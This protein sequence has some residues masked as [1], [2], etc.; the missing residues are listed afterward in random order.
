VTALLTT[1]GTRIRD[2]AYEVEARRLVRLGLLVIFA[3]LAGAGVWM[4]VTP[5]SGAAIAQGAVKVDMNRK[6]LQHQEGGI[7]KEI[8]VRNG[9]RVE[10]GQTLLVI[11]DV[12]VEANYDLLMTQ[13]DSEM[14]KGARLASESTI[15]GAVDY[16]QELLDRSED[17]RVKEL[18]RRENAV[19]A[20]RRQM[21]DGQIRLL[22]E[23]I[24]EAQREAAA[25]R[26]QV[27][28]ERRAV[29]WQK[30]E[31]QA[32]RKLADQGFMSNTK[33]LALQRGVAEYE[34]RLGEHQAALAQARQR[35]GDF[36]LRIASLRNNY[37]K[38]AADE[39]KD[40]TARIYDLRERLRPSLDAAQRQKVVAPVAGD[41][42]DLRV[43]TVG[44]VVGPREPLLDI[45][46][47]NPELIVES[48]VRPED[49][50]Y[51][52]VGGEADVRLSAFK[53][54]I[55]PTVT[56]KVVYVSADS[57]T[58]PK[59]GATYYLANI[60]LTPESLR[61]AG[62]LQLQAGMPA[63]VFVKTPARTPLQYLLD[64]LTG[65]LQRSFREP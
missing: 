21:L 4:V 51:V 45:V 55:T 43:N 14:A 31:L 49:I 46:P 19:F 30:E 56:G 9:T 64:P 52:K 59:T 65:F 58:D 25:L 34:A 44:A 18:M 33:L 50:T 38:E 22:K 6:T 5:L 36:E 39:L 62:N 54:R 27:E 8:L 15:E 20:T 11:N 57:L 37:V 29:D 7:V 23:Q 42:V 28:A 12:R 47:A 26:E 10:A 2:D 17:L 63:E 41:I 24:V 16:P 40:T 48:R 53:Q 35:A 1:T 32:N 13:L 3:L 61:D 60:K